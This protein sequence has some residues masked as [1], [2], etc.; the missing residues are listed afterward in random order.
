MSDDALKP[1]TPLISCVTNVD[2]AWHV[3]FKQPELKSGRLCCLGCLLTY[4]ISVLTIHASQP[5]KGSHCRWVG[6]SAAAFGWSRHWSVASPLGCVVQQQ[7]GDIELLCEKVRCDFLDNN[8]DN[9][10]VVSVVNF[11]KCVVT[12]NVLFQ[13]FF[14]RHWHF[15]T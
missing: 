2:Q 8:W 10:H 3:A 11:F 4:G 12:K 15:T 1:A 9:K 6:Q 7:G 5:D 13:L 14:L